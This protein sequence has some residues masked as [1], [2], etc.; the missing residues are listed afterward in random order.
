MGRLPVGYTELEYIESTGTQYIF[1]EKKQ[2]RILVESASRSPFEVTNA[3]FEL[4]HG[5]EVESSGECTVTKVSD[6]SYTINVLISPLIKC[7]VY[8]L[9]FKYT[10]YPENLIYPCRVRVI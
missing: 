9:V 7:T 8:D 3:K 5:S 1:G 4:R 10:I 2:A 6:H